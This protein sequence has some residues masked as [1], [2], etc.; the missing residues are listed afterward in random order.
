MKHIVE[1]YDLL[2]DNLKAKIDSDCNK[3]NGHMHES[4]RINHLLTS[5]LVKYAGKKV[6]MEVALV[7]DEE[8][9]VGF[10]EWVDEEY[11]EKPKTK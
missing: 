9:D 1:A 2:V 4:S 11:E 6:A 5:Q 7:I 8:F 10:A 3:S